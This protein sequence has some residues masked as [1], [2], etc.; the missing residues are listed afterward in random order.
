[1]ATLAFGGAGEKRLHLMRGRH[2]AAAD[3][4]RLAAFPR[5]PPRR[6]VEV[7]PR[8][9]G[10]AGQ[11]RRRPSRF[12]GPGRLFPWRSRPGAVV[13]VNSL[14]Y[15]EWVFPVEARQE[16]LAFQGQETAPCIAW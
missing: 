8:R 13:G 14:L 11:P 9:R 4:T 15:T 7:T 1:M 2:R 3:S 6:T 12:C 16:E 10:P 5:E